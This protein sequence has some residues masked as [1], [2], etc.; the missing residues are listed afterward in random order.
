MAGDKFDLDSFLT[1]A[2]SGLEDA[3][4]GRGVNPN[5]FGA[6]PSEAEVEPETSSEPDQ[7]SSLLDRIRPS[8]SQE[9][10]EAVP[11]MKLPQ[12]DDPVP[13]YAN[14]ATPDQAL[15]QSPLDDAERAKFSL[16][17]NKKGLET[18][19]KKRFGDDSVRVDPNNMDSY[20]V[21]DQG[22]WKAVDPDSSAWE[23][24][25]N[26]LSAIG[27]GMV[28]GAG[29]KAAVGADTLTAG[30]EEAVGDVADVSRELVIVGASVGAA[31]LSRGASIP[32]QIA[33]QLGAAG[34]LRA[35]TTS[36]G[37][38]IGTYD[39][40]TAEQL[41]DVGTEMLWALGG[42]TMGVGI[43]AG[44]K[45]ALAAVKGLS[46]NSAR[47]AQGFKTLGADLLSKL[48]GV[49]G[50]AL[51]EAFDPANSR[52]IEG[53]IKSFGATGSSADDIVFNIQKKQLGMVEKT[54]ELVE[55]GIDEIWQSGMEEASKKVSNKNFK[56]V[57]QELIQP[58]RSFALDNGLTKIQER[59]V[60]AQGKTIIRD[61]A[62]DRVQ[63]ELVKRKGILPRS[64]SVAANSYDE[65]LKGFEVS[66]RQLP[67]ILV[68]SQKGFKELQKFVM[69]SEKVAQASG[70]LTGTQ[71]FNDLT[72]LLKNFKKATFSMKNRAAKEGLNAASRA[73]AE[74][75]NGL[76]GALETSLK[77]RGLDD[78]L[79]TFV[80]TKK[81]WAK[82]RSETQIFLDPW[83][84]FKST[85]DRNVLGKL[86]DDM[87]KGASRKQQQTAGMDF[88]LNN[89]F[90]NKQG[91]QAQAKN[92][93]KDLLVH[94]AAIQFIP[95]V[96]KGRGSLAATAAVGSAGAGN[97]QQAAGF[98]VSAGISSPR[99]G[100]K[101]IRAYQEIV[102]GQAARSAKM[103][104]TQEA[105]GMDEATMKSLNRYG[106]ETVNFTR[107]LG[108]K[109][110][111]FVMKDEKAVRAILQTM[112]RATQNEQAASAE[113]VNQA[114]N[115]PEGVTPEDLQ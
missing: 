111:D 65:A 40:T 90:K 47:W 37:R 38:A 1:S 91:A 18:E 26:L 28:P 61:V 114:T 86:S 14:G 9:Q 83:E 4:A 68:D 42:E 51:D 98:T 56:V 64:W 12:T 11:E 60:T 79:D 23:T 71:G 49:N 2:R 48:T 13:S 17:G 96:G 76:D 57:A 70:T 78:A 54:M 5:D 44:V 24:T 53:I 34:A 31:V 87:I 95:L 97:L 55:T 84:T 106:L 10:P 115:L 110:L 59:V 45:G 113:L 100:L 35:L 33:G 63:A 75:A 67:E 6:R 43:K 85:K 82:A 81:S 19:L 80:S 92:L 52:R 41:Q 8:E 72:T 99:L 3:N 74:L 104:A 93:Y 66:G 105:L 69:Q 22:V 94:D 16:F 39:A 29:A 77:S 32:I 27:K 7:L 62:A 103:K 46:N 50:R 20:V 21:K 15:A 73:S 101:G 89:L 88:V 30:E 36:M 25:K 112:A 58:M 107:N 108:K 102:Q 109:G